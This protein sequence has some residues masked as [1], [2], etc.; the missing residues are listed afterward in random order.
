MVK[1]EPSTLVEILRWRAFNQPDRLAYTFLQD[2]ETEEVHLT[3][4]QLDHSARAIGARLQSAGAYGERA[5]LVYPPGLEIVA[6]FFGCLYG[7][8]AAIS[9]YHR[10][11]PLLDNTLPRSRPIV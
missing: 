10:H 9:L 11:S 4:A 5:L 3:Y 6:A 7:V 2:G 1:A 8:V